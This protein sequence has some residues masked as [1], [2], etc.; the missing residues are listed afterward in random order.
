MIPINIP[1]LSKSD[2]LTRTMVTYMLVNIMVIVLQ[3]E[4]SLYLKDC[5]DVFIVLCVA[6]IVH[7]LRIC[8]LYL[9][10]P[11]HIIFVQLCSLVFY[12]VIHT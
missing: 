1:P 5:D 12:L 10:K 4:Q 3:G 8:L 9:W 11:R 6:H 7:R 2:K